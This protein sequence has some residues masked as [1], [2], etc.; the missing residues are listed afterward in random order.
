MALSKTKTKVQIF[1][2][3]NTEVRYCFLNKTLNFEGKTTITTITSTYEK[4]KNRD[5]SGHNGW[6]FGQTLPLRSILCFIY[7][8]WPWNV[9]T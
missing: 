2:K 9:I 6:Y 7:Y 3:K 5:V 4:T 8:Y 1:E